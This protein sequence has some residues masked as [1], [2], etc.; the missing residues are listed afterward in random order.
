MTNLLWP[1]YHMLPKITMLIILAGINQAC[2]NPSRSCPTNAGCTSGTCQCIS[3][4]TYSCSL[5]YCISMLGN[6][7]NLCTFNFINDFH[8]VCLFYKSFCFIV[9]SQSSYT[10]CMF[11]SY[12]KNSNYAHSTINLS[13]L[14]HI[15]NLGILVGNPHWLIFK[16]HQVTAFLESYKSHFSVISSA[17]LCII[18]WSIS[19]FKCFPSLYP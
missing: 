3:G 6:I 9:N 1:D 2:T 15:L 18:S 8:Y 12:Q 4:Y 17:S 14:L 5:G 19:S 16:G 13:K 11:W 7:Q 10:S